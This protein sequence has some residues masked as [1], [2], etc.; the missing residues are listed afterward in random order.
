MHPSYQ[1]LTFARKGSF[2]SVAILKTANVD[3]KVL[4]DAKS[5]S[6]KL[7]PEILYNNLIYIDRLT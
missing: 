2:T 6:A 7:R 3:R 5:L 4:L 1:H